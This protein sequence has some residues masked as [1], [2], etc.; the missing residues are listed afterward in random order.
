MLYQLKIN[1]EKSGNL[2]FALTA[3]IGGGGLKTLFEFRNRKVLNI[4]CGDHHT[5]AL[6]ECAYTNLYELKSRKKPQEADPYGGDTYGQPLVFGWGENTLGQVLGHTE[7]ENVERPTLIPSLIG[8]KIACIAASRAASACAE[9]TGEVYE[10]GFNRNGIEKSATLKV[11]LAHYL[12]N[13]LLVHNLGGSHSTSSVSTCTWH[14]NQCWQNL[15]A[16]S[17]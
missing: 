9:K 13:S 8:K 12:N 7:I 2:D 10:W 16:G 11:I 5:I 6:V 15:D 1:K 4:A 14:Y 3:N 17:F